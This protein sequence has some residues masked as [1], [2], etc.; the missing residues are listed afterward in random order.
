[1]FDGAE[2]RGA[3]GLDQRIFSVSNPCAS[4][5]YIC[6]RLVAF[7]PTLLLNYSRCVKVLACR[8]QN[9][10]ARGRRKSEKGSCGL[11]RCAF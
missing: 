11:R 4:E 9:V 6:C 2:L 5:T 10:E 3:S 1:M 8:L 7:L